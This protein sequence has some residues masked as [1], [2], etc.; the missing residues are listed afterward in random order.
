[1]LLLSYVLLSSPF[2]MR[3]LLAYAALAIRVAAASEVIAVDNLGLACLIWKI[4][5]IAD[6]SCYCLP[7]HHML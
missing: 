2:A 1:M 4:R 6:L 5:V 3:E 7:P